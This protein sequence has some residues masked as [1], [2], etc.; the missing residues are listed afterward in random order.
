MPKIDIPVK[1]LVQRRPGDWVKYLNPGCAE[2]RVR[3]FKSEYTPRVESR[4]DN[5][6][7]V[8]DPGGYYLVNFEPMG[9]HDV[10]LPAR[11]MRYRSD[12]W[13]ATLNDRKG[14]PPIVQAVFFFY[15]EHDN[16]NHRL[17]DRW[18][19]LKTVEFTY[20]VVRVW[21]QPRQPVIEQRLVGLYP[22]LPL[23]KGEA[24]EDPKQVLQQ[25][26]EVVREV[27][28][29]SLQQD[30]LAVMG[31]LAG[32][33]YAAELVYSMIRREMILES[34]IYQEWVKE[35]RA[36]AEARG[37]AEGRAEGKVE[38]AQDAICKYLRRRFGDASAGLQQKVR[39]MTSLEVLDGV[40]EELFAANTLEEAQAIIRDGI[41][42]LMQ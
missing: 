14:T 37:R 4:L 35:E 29:R 21:E 19:E 17:T 9:Y 1:R 7:E 25:S 10:A 33:I 27:E 36:E 42:R 28:D 20:R 39:E 6:F 18:G 40:M 34:P 41:E 16:K 38:K 12:I 15:P 31:I 5:V 23:M 3:P 13:E 24:G 30:L 32:G 8:E 26:I 11:M 22:L 2:D